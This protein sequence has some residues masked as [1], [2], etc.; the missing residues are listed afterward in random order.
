M[1]EHLELVVQ[2][3]RTSLLPWSSELVG[4]PRLRIVTGD[5][6]ALV[7]GAAN[8][9]YDAVLIDIDDAPDLLWH[10]RHA[11]FYESS[12][13][14]AVREHLAPGGVLAVWFATHPGP[15]FVAAA[16]AS[17]A[18]TELMEIAFENPCLRQQETNYVLLARVPV[19]AERYWA[20][21]GD[22]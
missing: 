10:D 18:T 19:Y 13:L 8:S 12:G 21:T 5:F 17:F 6:H 22:R 15:A 7:A 16:S 11:A 3:H 20:V 9:R 14:R 2:W 1:V 4:D